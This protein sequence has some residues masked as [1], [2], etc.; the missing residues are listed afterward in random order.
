VKI[1]AALKSGLR[2]AILIEHKELS[3]RQKEE[4]MVVAVE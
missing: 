2:V 1:R 4:H 3:N